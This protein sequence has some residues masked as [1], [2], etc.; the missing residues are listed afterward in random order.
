MKAREGVMPW[1]A[2]EQ[3]LAVLQIAL[4]RQDNEK[5]RAVLTELVTGYT[6][7]KDIVDWVVMVDQSPL[8]DL[9][10]ANVVVSATTVQPSALT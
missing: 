6:A 10:Q 1:S 8:P 2:L 7:S 5:I 3:H 9:S 4:A